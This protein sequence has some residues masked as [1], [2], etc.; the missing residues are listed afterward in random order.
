MNEYGGRDG[1]RIFLLP[2]FKKIGKFV[3]VKTKSQITQQTGLRTHLTPQQVRFVRLLEM[4]GPEIEEAV[5]NELDENP[6]LE[7][8]DEGEQ[9]AKSDSTDN[10][11][12]FFSESSEQL[13]VADYGNEDDVPS[14]L[15]HASN[16]GSGEEYTSIT[17]SQKDFP[18]LLESLN[19]QLD[20]VDAPKKDIAI[21][22]YLAGYL[23]DNGRL[24]RSLKDIADDLTIETGHTISR[25]DLLP[26]LDIIRYQL[27]PAGLGAFDLR[28][29]LL[30]QLRRRE[31]KTEAVRV[32]EEIVADYFDLFTKKHFDK[33]RSALNVS[34]PVFE[35]SLEAI[36]NLDP[37]PG[38]SLSDS[39]FDKASHITP[40]FFVAPVDDDPDRFTVSLNQRL[41]ELAV[42]ETFKIDRENKAE[43]MFI[44]KKRDEANSFISLINRRSETLMAVMKAIVSIQKAFFETEDPATL[45]PMILNDL[46]NLTGLDRSVISR[47]TQ[48]KYVAT[49]GGIY[50]LKM[51]FNDTPTNDDETSVSEI[52]SALKKIIDGENKQK[53]LSDRALTDLL[54]KQGYALARRTVTKYREKINI[55]VAR[56]R[57]EYQ[58][59]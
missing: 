41:P 14:Y 40:D 5:R 29:C 36:R 55:P 44:R 3:I 19:E 24:S 46:A 17:D 13:Q 58:V 39:A 6:A 23:D 2:I 57:K 12:D 34:K 20:M 32:A 49:Q 27:D 54:N 18:S 38:S 7:A 31:P 35:E 1:L 48:G 15:L 11:D 8:L 16:G 25:N 50:P 53:P 47:A 26:G 43:Q 4:S 42:E 59:T 45:R 37:K 28:E 51:F 22:R 52:I 10:E 9:V 21:A 33:L 30:I 56:L